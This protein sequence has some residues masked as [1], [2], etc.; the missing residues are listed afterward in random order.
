MSPCEVVNEGCQHQPREREQ[1]RAPRE[2]CSQVMGICAELRAGQ[3]G[4]GSEAV[5]R[6]FMT[7]RSAPKTLQHRC[8]ANPRHLQGR[9][10]RYLPTLRPKLTTS[11]SSSRKRINIAS[12]DTPLCWWWFGM[13]FSR[14]PYCVNFPEPDDR[15]NQERGRS[16]C[17]VAG[18]CTVVLRT[19]SSMLARVVS[20]YLVIGL[21]SIDFGVSN[22]HVCCY[23]VFTFIGSR[24]P[25]AVGSTPNSKDVRI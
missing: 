5:A 21:R 24:S 7:S 18:S 17:D 14:S 9:L 12:M 23:Y 3:L 2:G 25:A 6:V 19:V 10:G 16:L 15:L 4:G 11:V 8:A 1:A 13:R 22:R 20:R